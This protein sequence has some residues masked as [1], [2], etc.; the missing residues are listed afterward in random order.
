MTTQVIVEKIG[1]VGAHAPAL[2]RVDDA[3]DA[4]SIQGLT[5][6]AEGAGEDVPDNGRNRWRRHFFSRDLVETQCLAACSETM[7]RDGV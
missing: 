6:F 1:I 3:A 5:S 7:V 2:M 4:H